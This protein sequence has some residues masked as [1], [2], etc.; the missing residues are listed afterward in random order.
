M[1]EEINE[2]KLGKKKL[3]LWVDK[4]K[5]ELAKERGYVLSRVAEEALTVML[6]IENEN[7]N[8]IQKKIQK[9]DEQIKQLKLKRNIFLKELVKGRIER[10]DQ[11]LDFMK[12]N[13]LK[14]PKD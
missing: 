7:E 14:S 5:V 8:E 10:R 3:T 13:Q 2:E 11:D 12:E 1:A 9:I 4:D 6:D